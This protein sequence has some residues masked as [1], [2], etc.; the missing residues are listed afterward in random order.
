MVLASVTAKAF[1]RANH[2][3]W[4]QSDLNQRE[5]RE[6]HGLSRKA[7]ENWRAKFRVEPQPLPRKLLYRAAG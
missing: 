5:Y 3:A 7:F 2:E 6:V 4:R 1:W